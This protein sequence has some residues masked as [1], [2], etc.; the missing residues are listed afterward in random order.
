MGLSWSD[1]ALGKRMAEGWGG[2]LRDGT[3]CGSGSTLANAASVS[4]ALPGLL[5]RY[6]IESM[7]DAG[8]GDLHWIN[9]VPLGVRYRAFDLVPRAALVETWD[10]TKQ[11]LPPA[12]AIL[13]R[14][15]LIHFDPPRIARTLELFAHSA[16]YLLASQ[17]D[18]GVAFDTHSRTRKGFDPRYDY[19]PTDLRPLLGEPLERL[20]DTGSDLALWRLDVATRNDVAA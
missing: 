16:K 1:E 3:P 20:P 11:E 2:G 10:I 17:Y 12:D 6:K 14:H 4:N 5:R 7:N 18:G 13:C 19:N 8:A 9:L 15:V